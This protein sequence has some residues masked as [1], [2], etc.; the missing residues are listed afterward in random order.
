MSLLGKDDEIQIYRES[1][2]ETW[3]DG[4]PIN[5]V[6]Y[7]VLDTE[8]TGL[9]PRKDSIVTIG[10]VAVEDGSICL[11]DQFEALLRISHNTSSVV[12]HGITRDDANEEGMDE[13]LALR[14]LLGYLRDGVI[15]GHHIGFD[16]DIISEHCQRRFGLSLENRWID[17]MELTLHLEDAGAFGPPPDNGGRGHDFSLD[18]LCRRFDIQPHDRHTAAGDAFITA[19]IFM[20]LLRQA[21]Q[22]GRRTLG[23][24]CERYED[25]S[26]T[27][28]A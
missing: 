16:V 11:D 24:L 18:G 25:P 4:T 1:F 7:I 20:K 5:Q 13:V 8:T 22:Y 10:A 26:A 15:V 12:V 17:T 3:A 14:L 23:S 2:D 6:R 21:K 9:D 19:Q 28:Q 27:P